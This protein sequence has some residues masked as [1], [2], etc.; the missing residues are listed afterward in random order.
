LNGF[1]QVFG[2]AFVINGKLFAGMKAIVRIGDDF[3]Q[4]L[5]GLSVFAAALGHLGKFAVRLGTE[6]RGQPDGQ[7]L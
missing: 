5:R 2:V 6:F 4:N 1:N 3:Q 7:S